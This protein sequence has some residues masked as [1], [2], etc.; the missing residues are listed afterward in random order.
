MPLSLRVDLELSD[1]V[2]TSQSCGTD[3]QACSKWDLVLTPS[4][5]NLLCHYFNPNMS[6][7]TCHYVCV[8]ACVHVCVCVRACVRACVCVH[9][10]NMLSST[11]M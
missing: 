2:D 3:Q 6:D 8:H 9:A 7:N 11:F 10:C 1:A 5:I 4:S